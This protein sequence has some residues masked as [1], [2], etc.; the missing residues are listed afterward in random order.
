V[1][2]HEGTY[3]VPINPDGQYYLDTKGKAI[4]VE[5][6][7]GPDNTIIDCT[8]ILSTTKRA[9]GITRGEG[10][11]T[12]IRGFTM[13]GGY[14]PKG[15]AIACRDTSPTIINNIITGNQAQDSGGAIFCRSTSPAKPI[16]PIIENNIITDNHA[17]NYGGGITCYT[18]ANATIRGNTIR[19]N[20]AGIRITGSPGNG[21][22]IFVCDYSYPQITNNVITGNSAKKYGGGFCSSVTTV[23]S[24]EVEDSGLARNETTNPEITNN[25][26]ANNTAGERGGGI[27]TSNNYSPVITYNTITGNTAITGYGGGIDT[28]LGEQLK[29]TNSILWN[30]NPYEVY[31]SDSSSI[32]IDYSDVQDGKAGIFGNGTVN[33]GEG[34]IDIE[35]LLDM[36]YHLTD[37]SPC[38]GA[39]T[40]TPEII[41]DI[42]GELRPQPGD[43]K[44]DTGADENNR[45]TPL[46]RGDVSGNG[47]VTAFDASLVLQHV[48]GLINLSE[49]QF[50]KGAADVGADVT[51]NKV[52]SALDAA[53]ILQYTVGLI[54]KFP[55][56][57]GAPILNAQSESKFLSDAI[58]TLEKI[59]L[60][61]EQKEVIKQLKH[62]L[63]GNILPT[64]T[65]LL[66]N[67]PNPFNPETWLPY[68][69]AQDAPVTIRIYNA[70][71]QFVYSLQLGMKQAGSYITKGRA[72]YWDGRDNF[73]QKVASG[74]YF[75]TLI[76]GDYT[77]TRRM[78][79]L[80]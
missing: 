59:S 3:T 28:D 75:Y 35:P 74:V 72:A 43:S 67:Y 36:N 46:P 18:A 41:N 32:T 47:S 52:V 7:N 54:T 64:N 62:F 27:F 29:V 26:I 63:V 20:S 57:T 79:V 5:S 69:L 66:Q 37:Y 44:P 76:A 14:A 55:A 51:G 50:P 15:G 73:G 58:S 45:P 11:N 48:V 53:L 61:R 8:D 30:N 33:W 42:D 10:P 34:N 24:S 21:G 80:K 60:D 38:I 6:K 78:V 39:G 68:K 40:D 19:N 4:K 9:F 71:G 56:E 17:G 1:L 49:S 31:I 77:E 12:V 13:T 2:V 65:A 22:G 25:I 70:K 23:S 16:S